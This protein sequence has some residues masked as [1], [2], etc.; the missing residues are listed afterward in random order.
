[1]ET[2]K[3]SPTET[4]S[5]IEPTRNELGLFSS[6]SVL[7]I[8]KLIFAGSPLPEVLSIIAR[9]VESQADGMFCTIWLPDED[10]ERLHCAAAPSLPGFCAHVGFMT[11]GPKGASCGTAVYR[12]EPVFVTDILNDPLWDDYRHLMSPYAIRSVWSR[13]LLT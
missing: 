6:E 5:K 12:K 2:A 8:L 11:V 3:E 7:N 4:R 1:M 13:P 10:G 9:L